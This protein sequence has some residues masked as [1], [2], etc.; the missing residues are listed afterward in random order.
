MNISDA[1]IKKLASEMAY[2]ALASVNAHSGRGVSIASEHVEKRLRARFPAAASS[3]PAVYRIQRY[4]NQ[5]S[6]SRSYNED[7]H[8][9]HVGDEERE[10]IL[11]TSDIEF[12][13]AALSTQQDAE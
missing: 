4:L 5:R 3:A 9:F 7:I 12:V 1:D 6:L 13:I 2:A 8:G 10:A 11:T